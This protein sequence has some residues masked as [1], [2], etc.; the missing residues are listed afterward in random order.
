MKKLLCVLYS[1]IFVLVSAFCVPVSAEENYGKLNN[2]GDPIF[3]MAEEILAGIGNPLFDEAFHSLANGESISEGTYSRAAAGLQQ[4]LNQL[5]FNLA[6][7]GYAD[8]ST[9]YALNYVQGYNGEERTK[10]VDA[11][12]FGTLLKYLYM[13][14]EPDHCIDLLNSLFSEAESLSK[15]AGAED[16]NDMLY[17]NL[18]VLVDLG[19]LSVSAACGDIRYGTIEITNISDKKLLIELV[20]GTYMAA[21]GNSYQNMLITE[22]FQAGLEPGEK[23]LYTLYTCCMN[24]HRAMPKDGDTFRIALSTEPELQALA[25]YFQEN[26]I[27]YPV[28]QAATWIITDKASFSDCCI[29]RDSNDINV[30]MDTDYEAAKDILDEINNVQPPQPVNGLVIF[31]LGY[32]TGFGINFQI[33]YPEGKYEAGKD[34]YG[35]PVLKNLETGFM[36]TSY[37]LTDQDNLSD[38]IQLYRTLY[39]DKKDFTEQ[40]LTIAG[41]EV[42]QQAYY[43][44]S[45]KKYEAI[46]TINL[47]Q[48]IRSFT[49]WHFEISGKTMEDAAGK[50][51]LDM[52]G[53]ITFVYE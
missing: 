2:G 53:S 34:A 6:V 31:K 36:M 35:Y 14:K 37:P 52:I 43:D 15:E 7:N 32:T 41:L 23:R 5:G 30:I 28:R 1:F 17:M 42:T 48:N 26:H 25:A 11:A 39:A 40:T 51:V 33:M 44:S 13:K 3:T 10:T 16:K 45:K 19:Y 9:F 46:Y 24:L 4:L 27:E 18:S 38:S 8:A 20:P 22:F 21:A 50:D 29:L 12:I 47:R 49:G